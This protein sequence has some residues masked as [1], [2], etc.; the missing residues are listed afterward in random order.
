MGSFPSKPAPPRRRSRQ[1]SH[2]RYPKAQ[3]PPVLFSSFLSP[4][5]TRQPK[6]CHRR[7]G[8][9][10]PSARGLFSSL[11]RSKPTSQRCYRNKPNASPPPPELMAY[12][13]PVFFDP[14]ETDH[15]PKSRHRRGHCNHGSHRRAESERPELPTDMWPVFK[16]LFALMVYGVLVILLLHVGCFPCAG[17][18]IWRSLKVAWRNVKKTRG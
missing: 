6:R 3:H 15:S 9:P 10:P 12:L 16:M 7:Y 5:P 18:L 2:R 17:G 8:N 11:F 1:Q 13:F 14:S 4:E